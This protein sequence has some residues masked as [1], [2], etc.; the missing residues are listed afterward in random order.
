MKDNISKHISYDEATKTSLNLDN[1]PNADQLENMKQ[2]AEHVFEP[3]RIWAGEPIRVNSM[4]RSEAVNKAIGGAR[5]SQHCANDGSAI[6]MDATGK[7]TNA[8]L[9]NYIRENLDFDQLIWEF[10]D[11]KNPGWVHVSF[12]HKR[13]NRKQVLRAGKVG[14]KTKYFNYEAK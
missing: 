8:D 13:K 9:F 1:T 5:N 6:D 12:C 2:I 4:F 7:K 11:D 3:L 10:G 14:M